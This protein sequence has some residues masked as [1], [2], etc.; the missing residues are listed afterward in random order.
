MR[1][2][3]TF[4]AV[5]SLAFSCAA[6]GD[7]SGD[8]EEHTQ[9][10]SQARPPTGDPIHVRYAYGKG[11][12][13]RMSLETVG[14]TEMDGE[15]HSMNMTMGISMRC[16]EVL[17]NGDRTLAVTIDG[18]EMDGVA[19]PQLAGQDISVSM[20][21]GA[22][23]KVKDLDLEGVDPHLAKTLK[24][25]LQGGGFA[26]FLPFPPEGLRV[27]E[28]IDLAKVVPMDVLMDSLNEVTPGSTLKPEIRGEYVLMGTTVIDGLEAA[29]F[30]INMVMKMQ[31]SM[32]E[33]GHSME[34]NMHMTMTGV[35]YL[36]L[37]SG[38]P[39][40]TADMEIEMDMAM[41]AGT[42]GDD[43]PRKVDMHSQMNMAMK[44]EILK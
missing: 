39:I 30:K 40:G 27:G 1:W 13:F 34:I 11:D 31:G 32:A 28:A 21:V 20:T 3:P 36:A 19:A 17:D 10:E 38:F 41:A 24:K 42:D 22:D 12:G 16:T 25:T 44:C 6:C 7:E 18:M 4:I 8:G 14:T 29:E 5:L 9:F 23:G 15:S 35:Q 43:Q 2:I 26:T 33:D 37:E